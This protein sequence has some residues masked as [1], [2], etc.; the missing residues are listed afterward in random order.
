MSL[1]L[2]AQLGAHVP[3]PPVIAAILLVIFLAIG[4]HEYCHAKFADLAGDPT[5]RAMGRVTLNLF[6]H[7]DLLGTIMILVTTFSGFGI[8]WGKPVI[9]DP[10]HMKNPK[11]DHFIAVLAGPMSNLV[12]AAVYAVL[13]RLLMPTGMLQ[14]GFLTAF[15][16]YGVILNVTLFVFNLLPIGPLDGMWLLGTFLSDKARI[17]WTRFNLSIGS[18]LFLVLV[19]IPVNTT[20]DSLL[21][22]IMSPFSDFLQRLLLGSGSH[23]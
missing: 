12:Q 17:S 16:L 4:L 8:G 9:M 14:G 21:F 20:G 11:W 1:P 13:L 19:L 2:V 18:L 5:P 23:A 3:P 22:V 15:L 6:K 7:F 10:R